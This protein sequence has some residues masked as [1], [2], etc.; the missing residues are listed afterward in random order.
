VNTSIKPGTPW[1]DTNGNRIQAHGGS[2]FYEND[3]FYWYGENKEKTRPGNGIWHWGVRAY[4]SKDLYNWKDEGLILPPVENDT[5]SPL[6]PSQSMD[7]PHILYNDRTKQ[8]VLWVKIM[9]KRDAEYYIQYMTIAVAD[10]FL[11]PYKIIKTIHP[12]GMNSGDFDLVQNDNDHKAYIYFERVHSEL[13]CA[14]LTDDYLDVTGYY[15]SHFPRLQ[16][17][18]VREAPAFFKRRGSLYLFS[19]G[20]TGY[21]PNPSEVA[22]S[23]LFHGPWTLLGD[24]HI[25]DPSHTSFHSQITS[26]FKHPKKKDLYI[27]LADRWLTDLTDKTPDMRDVFEAMFNPNKKPLYTRE[28]MASFSVQDTSKADYVWLP[29]KFAEDGR[30]F[31]EWL[32]EWKTE[33]YE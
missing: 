30:P 12:L 33:D 23:K 7:R 5:S 9:G 11:G 18:F 4:S 2:I 27:A 16:P 17:P 31:I 14:D 1:L 6:H 3:T 19:S 15:S 22:E 28:E 26:V 20:T 13:I 32:D 21:F 29:V 24:P 10:R 25:N 8:Y